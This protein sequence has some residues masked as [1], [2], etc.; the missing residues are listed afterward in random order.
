MY[1]DCSDLKPGPPEA[2]LCQSPGEQLQDLKVSFT[3]ILKNITNFDQK[4]DK[5]LKGTSNFWVFLKIDKPDLEMGV[6]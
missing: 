4:F 5:V 1:L 6:W 3:E 2:F